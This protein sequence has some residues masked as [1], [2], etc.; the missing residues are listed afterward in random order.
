MPYLN[1]TKQLVARLEQLVPGLA[2]LF[3]GVRGGGGDPSNESCTK[4]GK[5]EEKGKKGRRKREEGGWGGGLSS[6]EDA[7]LVYRFGCE[8]CWLMGTKIE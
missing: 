5:E 2:V 6:S 7:R 1:S 8:G 3:L 4:G